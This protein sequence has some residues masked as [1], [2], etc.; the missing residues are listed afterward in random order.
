MAVAADRAGS[1][2]RVSSSTSRLGDVTAL[3]VDES[4]LHVAGQGDFPLDVCFDGVRIL[5]FWLER[6]TE[7]EDD[8]RRL[9]AWPGVLRRFLD[10]RTTVTLVDPAD[11][12]VL[13]TAEAVLGS[14]GEERIRVQDPQGNPLGLD[15]SL[16]LTLLFGSRDPA[17]MEPLLDAMGTVLDALEQAGLEPFI[18]YGTLLGAVRDQDFIG[19]DSDA[20]LAYVSAYDHPV[21][22]ILE[23]FRVQRRIQEMGFSVHRYS[24]LA[25]KVS[26]EEEDGRSRGLDVF[27]GFMR[28]GTLYLM[29]EVGHPFRPEWLLPRSSATLAGRSFPA[30]AQPEHLLE[31]MYGTGWKVPDP[32]YKFTTPA[33]TTRRLNGWFRGLRVGFDAR[34]GRVRDHSEPR[35]RRV[36]SFI[37]EVAEELPAGATVLD[38]GCG[39]GR[40]VMWLGRHGVRAVG[41]DYFP[42]DFAPRARRAVHEDLPVDFRWTNLNEL[43]SVLPTGAELAR[44]PG[45]RIMVGRHIADATDRAGRQHLL[46]L[47][48]M[49]TRDSGR[50]YLQ[51]QTRDTE[52]SLRQGLRPLP[53]E[54]MSQLVAESGGVVERVT[55]LTEHEDGAFDIPPSED[56]PTICRMVVSWK[57]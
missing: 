53:P 38:V 4:G 18:A 37:K 1:L 50:L 31:A 8:Q 28:A 16:R 52:L 12:E 22:A 47:A 7:P 51:F 57:R 55:E 36:S 48:K 3:E 56:G 46:R 35:R 10:G 29:G 42:F 49:V 32:A 23:S 54:R 44:E 13:A 34:W 30:P 33:E 15:K 9:Y 20:D 2:C 21:D 41:L 11:G 25:F 43:R 24:G 27:G 17:Q 5:S 14:G 26:V 6:D 19:H 45:P 39:R 40:D